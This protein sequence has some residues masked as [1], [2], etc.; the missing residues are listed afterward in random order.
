MN[1]DSATF[2]VLQ[3]IHAGWKIMAV[4]GAVGLAAGAAYGLLS[5]KWYKAELSVV[6]SMSKGG[7]G[8]S[9]ASALLGVANLPFDLGGGGADVDRIDAL[10]RSRS[11]SDRVI[12]KFNL[13]ARYRVV[14]PEDAREA[15]WKLCTTK[16]ELKYGDC[17]VRR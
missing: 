16:I 15:L 8:L 17:V 5:P 3:F 6:P 4:T 13:M 2:D 14:Y 1:D 11:V 10:L 9:G 12:A 7:N